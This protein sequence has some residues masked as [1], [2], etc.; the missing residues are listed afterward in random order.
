MK[1]T[2]CEHFRRWTSIGLMTAAAV[3]FVSGSAS[4]Q[5]LATEVV[6]SGMAL[7]VYCTA[8]AG[9]D[10]RLFVVQLKRFGEGLIRLVDL[11]TGRLQSTPYLNIGPV[12]T[13]AE[14]GFY[15]M[16]FHPDFMHN[17]YFYVKYTAPAVPGVS[18]GDVYVVRYRA[19]GGDPMATQAD[20]A[21]ARVILKVTKP[22]NIHNGGWLGFG[23]D[24]YLYIATGDGGNANDT[25]G[26]VS[27]PPYHNP[28]TGN[29]QD[30]SDNILGK[31]LRI[32]V[33]GPDGVP[34]TD[35]DDAFPDDDTRN[36]CIPAGNLFVGTSNSPELWAWGVRNPWRCSFDRET[37]DF[38]FGDVGQADREEINRNVGNRPGL[39][40]GWRC[41]EG[42]RCTGLAGCECNDAALTPPVYEYT[43]L[44]GCAVMGGYVYRGYGIPWLRGTYFFNDFCTNDI[45]SFRMVGDVVTEF[46]DR[47]AEL[48]PPGPITNVTVTSFGE[49][50]RGD[51]YLVDE[52][53][54]RVLRIVEPGP[55]IDCNGNGRSDASDIASGISADA[56]GDGIP[57]ECQSPCPADFNQD[58]GVDGMDVQDFFIAWASGESSGDVNQDGGVDGNDV[59]AFFIPWEAGGC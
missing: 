1:A 22:E 25:T 50:S 20:P 4:A 34:G 52:N 15:C 11:R 46:T 29:A 7:P 44:D 33:N 38:W 3:S 56:N 30:L 23:P 54:G 58:G 6:A 37:G 35:D 59:Q 39:N 53:A 48:D 55:K 31:V 5:Q 26:G 47:S 57:D 18:A 51:L 14:Q 41:M 19:M 17:G 27:F 36:Y 16:A 12:G 42:T 8:P 49:D 45:H 10:D 13:Q 21:S 32:D 24:G 9:D 43:H 2:A 28:E 40:Y